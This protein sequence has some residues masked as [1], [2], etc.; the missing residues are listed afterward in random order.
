MKAFATA[1]LFGF[2]GLM[3]F[4]L[5]ATIG[6]G[7][8]GMY[9]GTGDCVFTGNHESMCSMSILDHITAWQSVFVSALVVFFAVLLIANVR[10]MTQIAPHL[11]RRIFLH[12]IPVAQR[13]RYERFRIYTYLHRALQE[14][15]ARGILH[16]KL[17]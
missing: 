15:F 12:T 2:V 5:S 4:S 9:A 11:L 3:F 7:D 8:T 6:H 1:V 14:L 17:H 13:L 10:G 16:P